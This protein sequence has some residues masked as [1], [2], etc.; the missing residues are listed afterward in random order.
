MIRTQNL[1]CDPRFRDRKGVTLTEVLMSLMIMSI[2]VSAVMVLFP[3]SVLRSVQSTQLTNAAILK[4][5]IESELRNDQ[6]LI[7]DPDGNFDLA[8][9]DAQRAFALAEHF[10]AVAA[11]NYVVDPA[12]FYALYGQDNDGNATLDGADDAFARSLG[13]TGTAAGF[14]VGTPLV[15]RFLPRFDGRVMSGF[16][17][18]TAVLSSSLSAD[19]LRALSELGL[20]RC[21]LGDGKTVQLDTFAANPLTRTL[22]FGSYGP[23]GAYLVG[24]QLQDTV[25]EDD[26]TQIPTS[27]NSIPGNLIADPENSE[28]VIFSANGNFSQTFPLTHID[29]TRRAAFWSEYDDDVS[30]AAWQDFNR[31]YVE[32][33]RPLPR[34]FQG[35]A[36]RVVL[37][38][39]RAADFTWL[40]TV[41]RASD[42]RV[43]GA[44][45]VVRHNVGI[46]AQDERAF[47]AVFTAGSPFVGVNNWADGTAPIIKRGQFILDP[48]NARWY[49]IAAVTYSSGSTPSSP[50]S[51]FDYRVELENAAIASSG[52]LASGANPMV[53]S[54]AV[55]VPHV[56]DVYPLGS[57]DFPESL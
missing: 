1:S 27:S 47:T 57:M 5:N 55:F 33:V 34:E 21:R 10:Q 20:K 22:P 38:S 28:I 4:R 24:I 11:R 37:R 44:D 53:P 46:T 29:A 13:N 19:Q 42:G 2:G 49:R 36:G 41:R 17:N 40:L 31:N 45:V 3:L 12:A 26:L 51:V 14:L 7:F 18:S 43:S 25:S 48:V 56:V 30:G 6:K 15:S 35:T 9:N 54:A 52:T 39:S 8:A 16:L 32:D 50:W 23:A